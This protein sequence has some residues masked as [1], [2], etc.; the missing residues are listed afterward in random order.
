MYIYE[1]LFLRIRVLGYEVEGA[2]EKSSHPFCKFCIYGPRKFYVEQ[3]VDSEGRLS[4]K[5]SS[6]TV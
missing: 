3:R 6:Y 2:R 1:M 5:H 4:D